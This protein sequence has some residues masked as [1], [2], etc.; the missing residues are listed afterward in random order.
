[1]SCEGLTENNKNLKEKRKSLKLSETRDCNIIS[2]YIVD[3]AEYLFHFFADKTQKSK[4]YAREI[5]GKI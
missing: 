1:M 4:E 5:P 3:A 2:T